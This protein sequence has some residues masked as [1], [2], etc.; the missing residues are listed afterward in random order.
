MLINIGN[1]TDIPAFF[2]TW[3]YN[4]IQEGSV[5]V[6]NPYVPQI[7]TRYRLNPDVVDALIFTT[8]NPAPMLENLDLISAYNQYWFVTIT[9]YGRDI[10]PGVPPVADVIGSFREL[11]RRLGQKALVWRYDPV[12]LGRKPFFPDCR[13]GSKG[14]P[15]FRVP[16]SSAVS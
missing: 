3:F 11:S 8:K 10:E 16:L 9:A 15:P 14:Y 13:S 6:R 4:R 7:I 2:S 12:F 1:R 5:C